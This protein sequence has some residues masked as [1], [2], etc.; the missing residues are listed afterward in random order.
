MTDTSTTP[1]TGTD[2]PSAAAPPAPP[3]APEPAKPSG[4]ALTVTQTGPL[5]TATATGLTP[6]ARYDVAFKRPSGNVDPTAAYADE[7]GNLTTYCR[8]YETGKHQVVIKDSAG[9]EAASASFKAS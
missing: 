3:T 6:G 9:V 1:A 4:E 5:A 7:E 8:V 2:E